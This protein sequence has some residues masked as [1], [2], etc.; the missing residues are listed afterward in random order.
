MELLPGFRISQIH[1][2]T[3]Q[4]SNSGVQEIVDRKEKQLRPEI[5]INRD[6]IRR[7]KGKK[8]ISIFP[9]LNCARYDIA[10]QLSYISYLSIKFSLGNIN[11]ALEIKIV[12]GSWIKVWSTLRVER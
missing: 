11:R 2:S 7:K 10:T 1:S 4:V 3:H 12:G 9:F 8:R 5:K 6:V